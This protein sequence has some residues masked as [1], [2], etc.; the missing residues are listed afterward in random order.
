MGKLLYRL[1]SR[2]NG[3]CP[4]LAIGIGKECIEDYGRFDEYDR[5]LADIYGGEKI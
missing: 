3:G 4:I 1:E 5:K 2:R